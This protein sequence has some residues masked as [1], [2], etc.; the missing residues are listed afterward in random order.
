MLCSPYVNVDLC[1]KQGAL[2]KGFSVGSAGFNF[3]PIEVP[4]KKA[5][6]N[7][8]VIALDEPSEQVT[9]SQVCLHVIAALKH[10]TALAIN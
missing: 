9:R 10:E 4:T 6:M 7:V 3:N 1:V 2:P 8:T 5:L